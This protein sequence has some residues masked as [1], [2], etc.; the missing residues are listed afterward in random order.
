[1]IEDQG[2]HLDFEFDG[3]RYSSVQAAI[4]YFSSQFSVDKTF[5]AKLVS[6]VGKARFSYALRLARIHIAATKELKRHILAELQEEL[7][8]DR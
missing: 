7:A 2:H 3:I 5:L 1:A 4:D 8:N 6:V